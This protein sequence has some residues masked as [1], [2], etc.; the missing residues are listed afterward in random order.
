MNIE[1]LEAMCKVKGWNADKL[2]VWLIYNDQL[3]SLALKTRQFL[4]F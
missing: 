4:A 3:M 1:M 2:E